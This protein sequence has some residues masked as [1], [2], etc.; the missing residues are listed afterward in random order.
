MTNSPEDQSHTDFGDPRWSRVKRIFQD[1]LE[2]PVEQRDEFLDRECRD[3]GDVRGEVRGML[4]DAEDAAQ[5]FDPEEKRAAQRTFENGAVLVNRFRIIDFIGSGGMGQVYHAEDMLS[6]GPVALKAIRPEIAADTQTSRR[7]RRELRLSRQVSHPNVCRVYELW[8][9]PAESGPEVVFLTME[10]LE[11]ET[12]AARL[13]RAGRLTPK[14]ALPIAKQVAAGIAEVHRIGIVHRDVKP[15]NVF[16]V[17]DAAGNDRAVVMDFGLARTALLKGALDVTVA[18]AVL[19]TPAY[20]APELFEGK[21]ATVCSDIYGFG[22]T[23]YEMLTGNNRMVISSRKQVT[24]LHAGWEHAIQQCVQPD[25]KKRPASMASVIALIEKGPKRARL[26]IALATGA[27]LALIL[28]LLFLSRLSSPQGTEKIAR[29]TFDKGLV[30]EVSYS[31]DGKT[32][33]YAS[34]QGT[35]EGNLNLWINDAVTGDRHP[36]VKSPWNDYAPAVSPD[37]KLVAFHSDREGSGLYT[38]STAGG[39]PK[40]IVAYGHNPRF[41]A[42]GKFI[43]YWVGQPGDVSEA[44]SRGYVIPVSG[45]DPRLIAPQFAD[46]RFPVWAPSGHQILFWERPPAGLL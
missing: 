1:A 8:S 16:L 6:G 4:D 36:L 17:P 45:G 46:V 24:G 42:D 12:L 35:A 7:F 32:M 41:S 21:E 11:G 13:A 28:S 5:F 38:V 2:L 9:M 29:L 39:S 19:G 22:V 18:G 23:L 3:D 43:A 25:P 30:Q 10:L 26:Q 27:V 37:G 31:G 15:S 34:D 33:V 44:V 40:F 20:M 14:A